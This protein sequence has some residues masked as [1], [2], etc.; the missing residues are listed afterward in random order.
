MTINKSIS[1]RFR[2]IRVTKHFKPVLI[3]IMLRIAEEHTIPRASLD[4]IE[5]L[6][7]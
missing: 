2:F 5:F 3:C 6:K 1:L 7:S 4:E